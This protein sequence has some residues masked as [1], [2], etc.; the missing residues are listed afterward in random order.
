MSNN[1]DKPSTAGTAEHKDPNKEV[2]RGR[3]NFRKIVLI[4]IAVVIL[5][6]ILALAGI[7]T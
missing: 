1:N 4:I 5:V 3:D 2:Y 6:A 7:L